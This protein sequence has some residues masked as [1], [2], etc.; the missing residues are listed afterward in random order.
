VR[1]CS[2]APISR[3]VS[4]PRIRLPGCGW[5]EN[6]TKVAPRK[7]ALHDARPPGRP[8]GARPRHQQSRI[9]QLE[10]A[11]TI[12]EGIGGPLD[13][14]AFIGELTRF[15]RDHYAYDQVRIYLWSAPKQRLCRTP[16]DPTSSLPDDMALADAGPLRDVLQSGKAVLL[17]TWA[18]LP[19]HFG[20][21][22]IG[23]LD[24]HSQSATRH[25]HTAH[26]GLLSLA[27]QV[28]VGLR[29]CELYAEALTARRRAEK[30]AAAAIRL[31]RAVYSTEFGRCSF[32]RTALFG[33]TPSGCSCPRG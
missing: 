29:N 12:G 33:R 15:V 28:G 6:V 3:T 10:P 18:T 5:P 17:R 24:L 9:E 20:G 7:L 16:A 22:V 32:C 30:I 31:S 21:E 2:Q 11:A 23:V 4:S 27:D 19:I 8:A 25:P 14:H 13:L 1:S 26:I